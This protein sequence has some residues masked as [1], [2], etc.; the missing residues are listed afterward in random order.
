[1]PQFYHHRRA[2]GQS[3]C[4]RK[5]TWGLPPTSMTK[6]DLHENW[7]G[8]G[9]LERAPVGSLGT[10]SLTSITFIQRPMGLGTGL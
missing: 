4:F 10:A 5:V 1:M 3:R 7:S 8:V 6:Q 2:N 9:Y